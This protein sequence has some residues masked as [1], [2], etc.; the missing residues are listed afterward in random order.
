ML[1]NERFRDCVSQG[2]FAKLSTWQ[3]AV[4]D[5]RN[6]II[7]VDPQFINTKQEVDTAQQDFEYE[8]P[9]DEQLLRLFHYVG[10]EVGHAISNGYGHLNARYFYG[11]KMHLLLHPDQAF[12][13]NWLNDF[14]IHEERFAEG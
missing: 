4:F 10:H 9:E 12:T 2:E 1:A 3:A 13:G 14:G 8:T 6:K 5:A 7:T 11:S